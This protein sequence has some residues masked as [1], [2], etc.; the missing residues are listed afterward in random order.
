MLTHSN[1]SCAWPQLYDVYIVL[2]L[3]ESDLEK[4]VKSQQNLSDAHIQYFMYQVTL[5]LEP[6]QCKPG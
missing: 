6:L 2:P 5:K 3:M 4:I 1:C